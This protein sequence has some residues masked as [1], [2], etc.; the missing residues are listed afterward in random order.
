ME[1]LHRKDGR[2]RYGQNKKTVSGQDISFWRGGERN[3]RV[4]HHP[5]CLTDVGQEIS[6]L[7][8]KIR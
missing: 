7:T 6:D 2:A 3:G 5:N 8:I 1:G 4:F